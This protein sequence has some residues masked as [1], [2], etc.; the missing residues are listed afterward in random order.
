M[1][2]VQNYLNVPFALRSCQC[3]NVTQEEKNTLGLQINSVQKSISDLEKALKTDKNGNIY[4]NPRCPNGKCAAF[5]EINK[6]IDQMNSY[7]KI[8]NDTITSEC[9]KVINYVYRDN[10]IGDS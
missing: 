1:Y 6:Q 8:M 2:N 5:V 3:V 7:V 9:C 4:E 10:L